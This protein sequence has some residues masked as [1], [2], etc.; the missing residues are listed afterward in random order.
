[1]LFILFISPLGIIKSIAIIN[2]H[3]YRRCIL[4]PCIYWNITFNWMLM[5]SWLPEYQQIVR[6]PYSGH[7]SVFFDLLMQQ[8]KRLCAL[9]FRYRILPDGYAAVIYKSGL[10]HLF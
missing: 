9:H 4:L 5:F 3:P 8:S 1:M 7:R 2:I 10:G 6:Y